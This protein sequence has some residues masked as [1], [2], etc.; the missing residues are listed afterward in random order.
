MPWQTADDSKPIFGMGEFVDANKALF[1]SDK[2][3]FYDKMLDAFVFFK[4]CFVGYKKHNF[5]IA[6]L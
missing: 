2:Q 4:I 3:A 1:E 5:L 6:S